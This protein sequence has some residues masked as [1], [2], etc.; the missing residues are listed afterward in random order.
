MMDTIEIDYLTR[1][2]YKAISFRNE[3]APDFDPGEDIFFWR[4]YLGQQ[5]LSA[6]VGFTCGIICHQP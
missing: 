1:D 6:T 3:K 2:F 4:R 5:Q